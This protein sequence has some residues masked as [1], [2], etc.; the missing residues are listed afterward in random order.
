MP[1]KYRQQRVAPSTE[2]GIRV[3]NGLYVFSNALFGVLNILV[4]L[5]LINFGFKCL[6]AKV[7]TL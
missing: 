4:A 2:N 1:R 3:M 5:M 7:V 6:D